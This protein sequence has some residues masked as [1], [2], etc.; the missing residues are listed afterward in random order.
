[1]DVIYNKLKKLKP[2]SIAMKTRENGDFLIVKNNH[3]DIFYLNDTSRYIYELCDGKK[4]IDDIY[5]KMLLEYDVSEE[6]LRD[7]LISIIRDF[8][9]KNIL[10]LKS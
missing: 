2:Y 7:D 1:M 3:Q 6:L 5:Q 4:N 10:H 9:W 8:Q